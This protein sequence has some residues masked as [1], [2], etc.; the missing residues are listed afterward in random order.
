MVAA[1][2]SKHETL[3]CLICKKDLGIKRSDCSKCDKGK[4]AGSTFKA[5]NMDFCEDCTGKIPYAKEYYEHFCHLRSR[6]LDQ[7]NHFRNFYG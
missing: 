7:E 3:N 5:C 4:D 2:R 1:V 6:K